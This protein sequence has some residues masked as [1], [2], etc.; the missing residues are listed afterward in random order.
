MIT[1]T[2]SIFKL[3]WAPV[4]KYMD[5]KNIIRTV[6]I[7]FG[8]ILILGLLVAFASLQQANALRD[9]LTRIVEIN[10][11]KTKLALEMRELIRLR[12]LSLHRM[13]SMNDPFDIDD[14][15]QRFY[16]YA[17][18]YRKAR[19][20]ILALPMSE[21]ER[22]VHKSLDN[23]VAIAQP[24]NQAAVHLFSDSTVSHEQRVQAV[25]EAQDKQQILFQGLN[26]L[27]D[28]QRKFTSEIFQESREATEFN[29]FIVI[30]T[31]IL[32]I[33][34]G[35]LI[36]FFVTRFVKNNDAQLR[37]ANTELMHAYK[38]AEAA[39]QA[40]TE[41]LANMSHEIR[42]PMNGVIGMLSLLSESPLTSEQKEYLDV[43]NKSSSSLLSLLN[44]ILDISKVEA[45]KL[46]LNEGDFDLIAT[47]EDLSVLYSE[48]AHKKGIALVSDISPK[49]P[50]Y[51]YGDQSRIEQVLR[52]IV[53]NAIKF[54]EDGEVR[55]VSEVI[56]NREKQFV[57]SL[58][59]IDT[60]IGIP[61]DFADQIF[62]TFTQADGTVT[63]KFGGSGLGLAISRELMILMN[64]DIGYHANEEGGTVFWIT[65]PLEICHD[66]TLLD[67]R[68]NRFAGKSA[69]LALKDESASIALKNMFQAWGIQLTEVE[70]VPADGAVD[71]DILVVD[72]DYE[73]LNQEST[74]NQIHICICS[75][76]STECRTAPGT[77]I[78]L[79]TPIRQSVVF[80]KLCEA[81]RQNTRKAMQIENQEKESATLAANTDKKVLVVDDN[82][83][84]QQVALAMLKKQGF[85]IEVANDGEEAL[86]MVS[87]N[88]YGLILMDCH[89]PVMD[90][91]AST[92]K[93]R[94]MEQQQGK[95]RKVIIAM[96]ANVQPGNYEK[97]IDS[98]MD[99][100]IAKPI[101]AEALNATIAKWL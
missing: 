3:N 15:T 75:V 11:Q 95:Q 31:S 32:L 64:G 90:G 45:G 25:A 71:S 101:T 59:I 43:A 93:I 8:L 74:D 33:V 52:N 60:G 80:D 69:T 99:D 30:V 44:D 63:R 62:Q 84:N 77:D 26:K 17:G 61:E 73:Q 16:E 21:Q 12:Q 83:F 100:F 13:L 94:D 40:K 72:D 19:A 4:C 67:E 70:T 18:H 42:T 14:E 88:D 27:V 79:S 46:E 86:N 23:A 54:T 91:Y 9:N 57:L 24:L 55:L 50:R 96:T 65:L 81:E 92:R 29:Y 39:T 22:M 38:R 41:F 68:K 56:E 10:N 85:T 98:G 35:V 82:Y 49:L 53:S 66:P 48:R 28:L 20:A 87:A 97:C 51:V 37:L 47:L 78:T 76:I 89:M 5:S 36:A 34:L 58:K 1:G 7:G 2:I 6:T